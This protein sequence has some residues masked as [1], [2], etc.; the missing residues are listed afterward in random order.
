MDR[1]APKE[2]AKENPDQIDFNKVFFY[3]TLG[4]G[5]HIDSVMKEIP[6]EQRCKCNQ[7]NQ[8]I[9]KTN[10][11]LQNNHQQLQYAHSNYVMPQ[12]RYGY[13]YQI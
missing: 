13:Q 9:P 7:K 5:M 6:L 1:L 12:F 10:Q 2:T 3:F 4:C 8:T 11:T